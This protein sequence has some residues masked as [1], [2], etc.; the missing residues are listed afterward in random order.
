M[1]TMFPYIWTFKISLCCFSIWI[2]VWFAIK[3]LHCTFLQWKFHGCHLS[4][5][6]I[7]LDHCPCNYR[8]NLAI[9]PLWHR[10]ALIWYA[11]GWVCRRMQAKRHGQPCSFISGCSFGSLN[12]PGYVWLPQIR[13]KVL[14]ATSIL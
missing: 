11:L 5:C 12:Y 10:E 4:Q 6:W 3:C 14:C 9:R 8:F 13:L 1:E 2:K 7:L